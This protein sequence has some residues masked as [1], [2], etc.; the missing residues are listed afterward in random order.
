[1]PKPSRR[2]NHPANVERSTFNV[3]HSSFG[4]LARRLLV[5]FARNAR[6]L[7]WRRTLDPYAVWISEVMLQQTQ[8]KTVI[9]YYE[10]WLRE[11]PDAHSL[12]RA[13]TERVLKLWEGLGYYTRARNLQRAAQVIV[14]EHGGSFPRNFDAILAL[15]GIGRYTAGAIASIAFNE[16]RPILDGNVIRVLT[17]LFGIRANPRE[18]ATNDLLWKLAGDLVTVAATLPLAPRPS[19]LVLSGPCSALNQALMELGATVCSPRS[20]NCG[21]CP[22]RLDCVAHKRGWT[23][24]LPALQRA[25]PATARRF[26]AFVVERR[27]RVLVRQRPADAL[28]GL[29]WEF[30]NTE[31][32]GQPVRTD[33]LARLLLGAAPARLEPLCTI[34]HSITRYRIT[35][36]AHV[37][38]GKPARL[39]A[40]RHRWVER[41]RLEQLAFTAAHRKILNAYLA[42]CHRRDEAPKATSTAR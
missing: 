17:R 16:P 12:A 8:V 6:G 30:P 11:L 35:V 32:N 24:E 18:R 36:D 2:T 7:P 10:R 1:M 41:E 13:R 34:K 29:L 9:P 21:Q 37:A 39:P 25:A 27:G 14:A 40:G 28:N 15:P 26:A 38:R 4:G 31:L 23:D 20:P 42:T 5:W 22:L 33:Q 3:Q 19:S